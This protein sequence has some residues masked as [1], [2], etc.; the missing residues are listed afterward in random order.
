V[1]AVGDHAQ[2]RVQPSR[3]F[4][5]VTQGHQPV[6]CTVQDERLDAH[7]LEV[8]SRICPHE[9]VRRLAEAGVQGGARDERLGDARLE[10]ARIRGVR[11][12]E[13]DLPQERASADQ[14]AE[15]RD[16]LAG[17]DQGRDGERAL[18]APRAGRDARRAH[19]HDAAHELRMPECEPQRHDPAERVPGDDGRRVEH[20]C[21]AVGVRVERRNR[22]RKRR[23]AAVTR[24]LRH[25]DAAR[26]ASAGAT[27][28]Q[29]EAAPPSPCSSSTTAGP[30]PAES[31][32]SLAPLT[33]Q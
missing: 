7:A 11:E 13:R 27:A 15:R 4:E 2:R 14:T 26:P 29:F 6:A 31:T 33:S 16:A 1:S 20:S 8:A 28:D 9:R 32:R 18:T 30:W 22:R 10:R 25:D 23:G 5:R 12:P 19:E 3:V 24:K 21:D 17:L